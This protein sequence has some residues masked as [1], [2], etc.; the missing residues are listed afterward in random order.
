MFVTSSNGVKPRQVLVRQS[1]N[2]Y[3][4]AEVLTRKELQQLLPLYTNKD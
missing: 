1:G 3:V 2:W 4:A